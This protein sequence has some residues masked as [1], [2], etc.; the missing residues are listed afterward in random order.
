MWGSVYPVGGV[1]RPHYFTLLL[2][3]E[4]TAKSGRAQNSK[5]MVH[6][7]ANSN[8]SAVD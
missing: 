7:E 6:L 5:I 1:S 3:S 2:Y 8:L 4:E